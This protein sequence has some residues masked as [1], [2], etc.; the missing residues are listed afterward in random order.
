MLTDAISKLKTE[1]TESKNPY[2][3]LVGQFLLQHLEQNPDDAACILKTDKSIM[4]SLDAMR[5]VAEKKKVGNMAVLSDDE[6]FAIVLNY[7]KAEEPAPADKKA[8]P[9]AEKQA[10]PVKPEQKAS[11]DSEEDFD[12]DDLL[13]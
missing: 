6:G 10:E 8:E 3:Q 2:V 5:K 7:F 11:E 13:Q 12:F 9:G 4:K 1:I